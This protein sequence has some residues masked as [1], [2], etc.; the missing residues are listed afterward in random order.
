MSAR[1]S[2]RCK[3]DSEIPK[4]FAICRIGA[5]PRRATATTSRRNSGGKAF[6]T[7]NILPART[8]ILTGQESTEAGASRGVVGQVRQPVVA[9]GGGDLVDGQVAEAAGEA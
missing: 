4:S 7:M 5:S 3:H 1:F 2:Q 9:L 8:T 6:G